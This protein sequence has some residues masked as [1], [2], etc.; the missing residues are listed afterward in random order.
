MNAFI[1]YLN[2]N[3]PQGEV[4][5]T[6]HIAEVLKV[7]TPVAYKLL[8]DAENNNLVSKYGYRVKGGWES[9]DNN[10]TMK[11]NGLYWQRD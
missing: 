11:T 2:N 7:K 1:E 9:A 10:A 4:R 5:N 3:W 6:K 8:C